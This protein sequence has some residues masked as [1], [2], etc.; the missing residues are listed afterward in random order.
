MQYL[1]NLRLTSL[2]LRGPTEQRRMFY[3]LTKL[4]FVFPEWLKNITSKIELN[5]QMKIRFYNNSVNH[6]TK[7]IFKYLTSFY[8]IITHNSR[9]SNSPLVI[10]LGS[11]TT[12]RL[13]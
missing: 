1:Y 10:S 13:S 6:Q 11:W 8:L 2:S 9:I 7:N 4:F 5:Q 12:I 3:N